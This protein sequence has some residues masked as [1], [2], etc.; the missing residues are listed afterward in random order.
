[1]AGW[2]CGSCNAENVPGT[3]FCGYCGAP[4][5][6]PAPEERRLIT[7]L[8]AD[9]SGFTNLAERL[10][11]EQLLEVIDPIVAALSTIVGRYEGHVEKYAGDALLALFGAPVTHDDDAA[12]ALRAAADMHAELARMTAAQP[13]DSGGLTLHV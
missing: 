4:R 2:I 6:A 12:R 10:D 7:A 11:A 1:M 3:R 9:L 8:F 13:R 5:A